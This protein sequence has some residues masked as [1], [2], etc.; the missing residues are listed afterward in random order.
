MKG[1]NERDANKP[2]QTHFTHRKST[3]IDLFLHTAI[4]RCAAILGQLTDY[5]ACKT[6][7]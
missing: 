2:S 3:A 4:I 7:S 6:F 5:E 1:K